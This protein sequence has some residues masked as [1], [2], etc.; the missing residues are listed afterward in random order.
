MTSAA[1]SLGLVGAAHA[2]QS[3]DDARPET[4]VVTATRTAQNV[5]NVPAT[6]SVITDRD[7]ENQL[8]ESIKD[9][10]RYEPG[11][12]V[13]ASPSRFGAALASTGRD[14]NSG[15]N[16]RGLEDNRVLMTVD[17]IRI[18][19]GFAYGPAAFGRGDYVDLD[20]LRS[21][22]IVRGPASALYGS[23]G[24][25]GAVSFI[26]RDPQDFLQGHQNF[27]GRA[28]VTYASADESWAE[29]L[30][31]AGRAGN[32][33]A[34]VSYTRRDGHELDNQGDNDALNATRTTPN[35]QDATSNAALA[36]VVY[37]PSDHQRFRLTY[38][39]GN[40]EVDTE[41]YS[42]RTPP[43]VPPT[44]PSATSVIDL[45]GFDKS[46]RQRI[47]FDHHFEVDGS[48]I[49]RGQWAIYWQE[50]HSSEFSREDRLTAADRTRLTTFDN[51]VWG[52][53]IQLES[54]FGTGILDHHLVYGADYSLT[55]QE[56]LRDG[57]VP[58]LGDFFPQRPFP[59]TD[60]TLAG[61]FAQDEIS[62]GN[63]ALQIFPALRY[64][65]Y[66]LSPK[67]D[68]LFAA[69]T[70]AQSDSH[71]S[72]KFGIVFWP[73]DH[74]GAFVNYAEGFKAP[75]PSQVNNFFQNPI[76]GYTSI[77]NPDLRPETSTSIEGGLRFRDV[78]FAGATWHASV[79][80]F[81]GW[82]DD[83]ISQ[84]VVSGSG[85]PG[86]PLVFQYINL[87][88]VEISGAE[89]RGD[90]SWNNGFG[91]HLAA[92]TATGTN[93]TGGGHTPLNTIDPWKFVAGL[94]YD[95]PDGRFGGQLIATH[96]EG[97]DARDIDQSQCSGPCFAP[98][99]FTILDLTAYWNLTQNAALRVGAF[100]LT[101]EKY[102]WWGDVR[103]N[104]A[105]NPTL[106]A[107]TQPG[108]NFSVSLG[109]R[110]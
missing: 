71:L 83:F 39:W 106:D 90:A 37:A 17:G 10:V 95:D 51:S 11:V 14:G 69:A 50:S 13:R 41:A 36:R 87:G 28:R 84:Q 67:P 77:P 2:Q 109:Y 24:L 35:P 46:D 12:S 102:W 9:I 3:S 75:A 34:Y 81:S 94:S 48:F 40:R 44:L 110:F 68:A 78:G 42:G 66:D 108:R 19:D 73:S 56:G 92:S 88:S 64:D 4:V 54:E 22:E 58:S 99:N 61:A 103:G 91:L 15:F 45:D 89:A 72:P 63:G 38:D 25:A 86:D 57:T 59:T 8:A 74:F 26:T 18:P 79:S 6:V 5:D 105:S 96:S 60:Y 98:G 31:G 101:D 104:A 47:S 23:D 93:T 33:S 21:V 29:N 16:I 52:G 76:F 70:A 82:Y 107:Y 53:A 62:T 100:N 85:A 30:I 1:I 7:I 97:K 43:P 55:H 20:L 27:A 32:W 80:V 49:T 65:Y